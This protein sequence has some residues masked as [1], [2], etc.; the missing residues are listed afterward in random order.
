MRFILDAVDP[1]PS[2]PIG[3]PLEIFSAF[4]LCPFYALKVEVLTSL[5]VFLQY[6]SRIRIPS[7]PHTSLILQVP[8]V[9]YFKA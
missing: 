2:H 1:V 6:C 9:V 5:L 7:A 8:N 4:R 3:M